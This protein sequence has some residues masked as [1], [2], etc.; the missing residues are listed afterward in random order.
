M[1]RVLILG[2]RS[3]FNVLDLVDVR[4]PFSTHSHLN[5]RFYFFSIDLFRR[6]NVDCNF[7]ATILKMKTSSSLIC[8]I[9]L[10]RKIETYGT[11]HQNWQQFDAKILPFISINKA[12][13]SKLFVF[14][15]FVVCVWFYL[16]LFCLFESE[17][18]KMVQTKR[19]L[20]VK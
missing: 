4:F 10:N 20:N 5:I 16:I 1:I 7:I 17:K 18:N 9:Y 12:Q 13:A 2:I 8:S 11:K 15:F 3:K 6:S 19:K 14:L